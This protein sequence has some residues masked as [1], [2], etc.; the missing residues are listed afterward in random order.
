MD[1]WVAHDDDDVA[2]V[3]SSRAYNDRS[4]GTYSRTRV[5]SWVADDISE[6]ENGS[7]EEVDDRTRRR[8]RSRSRGASP[9]VQSRSPTPE[10]EPDNSVQQPPPVPIEKPKPTRTVEPRRKNPLLSLQA[11]LAKANTERARL[12]PEGPSSATDSKPR[13]SLQSPPGEE[14]G[15]PSLLGRLS[16]ATPS[17]L[18]SGSATVTDSG[19]PSARR[20]SG[21]EV[22]AQARASVVKHLTAGANDSTLRARLLE[23]LAEE[24]KTA[25]AEPSTADTPMSTTSAEPP[26]KRVLD[27]K[28]RLASEKLKAKLDAEKREA[29]ESEEAALKSKL[30]QRKSISIKGQALG[31]SS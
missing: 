24:R 29:A 23:R 20:V 18:P 12:A 15:Q 14:N 30:I 10:P 31:M 16:I 9:V 13:V 27:H 17:T 1:S 5:D 2:E 25:G 11:H 6:N 7:D 28:A 21:P 3:A 22:T 26:S 4:K 19:K 8:R